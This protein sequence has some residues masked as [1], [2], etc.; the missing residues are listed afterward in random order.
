MSPGYQ[1]L[2]LIHIDDVVE[3]YVSLIHNIDS[4][5][6]QS[7]FHIGTNVSTAIRELAL[8]IEE[9]SL[10]KCLINWG[11]IPYREKEKMSNL[12]PKIDYGFWKP[13]IS[14]ID[15]LKSMIN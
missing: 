15:G 12:A 8:Q 11:G 14:L 9:I 1:K 3:F 4:I 2:D 7:Y 5:A 13:K 6:S 10:K